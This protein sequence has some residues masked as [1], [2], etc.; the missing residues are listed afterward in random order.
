M[1]CLGNVAEGRMANGFIDSCDTQGLFEKFRELLSRV[2]H[3]GREYF[4]DPFPERYLYLCTYA[5]LYIDRL[6]LRLVSQ[7]FDIINILPEKTQH[8]SKRRQTRRN[9]KED[10]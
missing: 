4:N 6:T 8:M 7:L 9:I 3:R 10:E 5:L 2:Q 1:V